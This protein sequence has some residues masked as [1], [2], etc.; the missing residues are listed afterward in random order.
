MEKRRFCLVMLVIVLAFGMTVVGCNDDGGTKEGTPIFRGTYTVSGNEVTITFTEM[1]TDSGWTSYPENGGDGL[2]PKNITGTINGNQF[3]IGDGN[4]SMTFTKKGGG[5]SFDGTWFNNDMGMTLVAKGGSFTV[6]FMPDGSG[7]GGN[8]GSNSG[9]NNGGGSGGGGGGNSGGT[10]SSTFVLTGMP[11][12]FNK[13]YAMFYAE[14]NYGNPIIGADSINASEMSGTLIEIRDGKVSLKMWVM[15]DGS[16]TRYHGD[17]T[18]NGSIKIFN[19]KNVSGV[20]GASVEKY[21]S[22][23]FSDGAATKTWSQGQNEPIDGGGSGGGGSGGGDKPVNPGESSDKSQL[24]GTWIN[25]DDSAQTVV[26]NSDG[27]IF[28]YYGKDGEEGSFSITDNTITISFQYDIPNME[29]TYFIDGNT[30]TITN[31]D[32]STKYTKQK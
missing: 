23:T 15:H 14:D 6:S 9:D 17:D 26:F 12:D 16:F 18:V 25:N 3:T 4:E 5:S 10:P 21:F 20:T 7:G 28:Y 11:N 24:Y 22:V 27:T 29:V 19:Y 32:I 2:P 8:G 30:L 31:G 13:K 1:N